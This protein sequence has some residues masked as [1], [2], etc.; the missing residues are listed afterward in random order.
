MH[1][2]RA[3]AIETDVTEEDDIANAVNLTV[4]AFG[5]LD[6]GLNFAGIVVARNVVTNIVDTDVETYRKI[7]RVDAE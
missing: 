5:R 6:Y 4:K 7:Q 3:I 2:G 1:P